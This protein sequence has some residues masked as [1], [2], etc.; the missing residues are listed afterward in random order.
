MNVTGMTATGISTTNLR[1]SGLA[2]LG[3]LTTDGLTATGISTSNL[4]VNTLLNAPNGMNVTGMTAT[5]IST[6]ELRADG[7]AYL[8][9]LTTD[10]LTATGITT[11][12]LRVNGMVYA[13]GMTTA[14]LTS[15]G[16][17]T[18]NLRVSNLVYATGG[19]TTTGL[20][21]TG[22]STTNLRS[23]GLAYLGGLTT[24][25]LTATGISTS[26]LTVST[27]LNATSGM[28]VTGMTATGISTT[29][30]RSSGLAY[31]GGVTTDGLTATGISTTNL[32]I[33]NLVYATGGVTTTGLTATGIST[34]NLRATNLYVDT[35]VTGNNVVTT[36]VTS[37]T[38]TAPSPADPVSLYSTASGQITLGNVNGKV[39]ISNLIF[40]TS[41]IESGVN[42]TGDI[43]IGA[44]QIN[45]TINI[46]TNSQRSGNIT[47]GGNG[48]AINVN[49]APKINYLMTASAGITTTSIYTEDLNVTGTATLAGVTCTTFRCNTLILQQSYSNVYSIGYRGLLSLSNITFATGSDVKTAVTFSSGAIGGL[50]GIWI[51][52]F[53]FSTNQV[54]VITL[55]LSTTAEMD[56][57]TATAFSL[58]QNGFNNYLCTVS[59][60]SDMPVYLMYTNSS[61]TVAVSSISNQLI[62][63]RIA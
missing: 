20:T 55:S 56:P 4:T 17:S 59:L 28:N 42:T 2:Y 16:I 29:N 18:T 48:N 22:I 36:T 40:D 35:L 21:A 11:G 1:A 23:S 32:R 24:D 30:L 46:G 7:L 49:G 45:G 60:S 61:S 33:S 3:G 38:I 52:E 41:S 39:K 8:G 47:I 62:T 43:T 63:T 44:S 13:S 14:G 25:G 51:Y 34:T 57:R 58:I 10:G 15:T 5:G 6:T 31:L 19:V 27:L 9:G 53:S 26:N 37:Q 50:Q 54:S 12:N